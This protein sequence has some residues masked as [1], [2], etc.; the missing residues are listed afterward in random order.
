MM[1]NEQ[2]KVAFTLNSSKNTMD[3]VVEM[4]KHLANLHNRR[5]TPKEHAVRL[6]ENMRK[7]RF[8]TLISKNEF[9]A[10]YW[11]FR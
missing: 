1:T 9:A 11:S 6:V 7:E 3:D 8:S 5:N 10:L 2:A 4:A